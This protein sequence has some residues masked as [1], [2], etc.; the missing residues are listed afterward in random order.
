[1]GAT[2]IIRKSVV[3]FL[4]VALLAGSVNQS[5]ALPVLPPPVPVPVAAASTAGA[6]VAGGFIGVVAALCLYDIWL[7]MNGLKNWDGT[8]KVMQHT[9]H[10]H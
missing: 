6:W 2:V 3:A 1:M 4:V 5:K 10:G 9:R 8:P 7:K